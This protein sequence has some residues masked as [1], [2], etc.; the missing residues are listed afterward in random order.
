MVSATQQVST[1]ATAA[2]AAVPPARSTSRPTSAV[3]GWLA[4]TPPVMVSIGRSVGVVSN[5]WLTAAST[6]VPGPSDDVRTVL[7]GA[8]EGTGRLRPLEP[9]PATRPLS[10]RL[11]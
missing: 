7:A 6:T 8:T 9:L 1:A 2:S 10:D 3:A 11:D 5:R 4:A